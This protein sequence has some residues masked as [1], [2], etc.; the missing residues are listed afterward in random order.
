V[1]TG[2][3]ASEGRWVFRKKIRSEVDRKIFRKRPLLAAAR[4]LY[5]AF[6]GLNYPQGRRYRTTRALYLRGA[7]G[8]GFG[9]TRRTPRPVWRW[10]F[11]GYI[12]R[13]AQEDGGAGFGGILIFWV[14][15]LRNA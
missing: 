6:P 9:Q 15:V 7:S 3:A 12:A 5:F 10:W 2:L 1:Q 13:W 8:V 11:C 14:R 4:A